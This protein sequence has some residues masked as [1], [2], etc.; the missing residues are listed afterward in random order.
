MNTKELLDILSEVKPGLSKH[1]FIEQSTCFIF[2]DKKVYTYNDEISVSMPIDTKINGAVQA[3]ELHQLLCRV[4]DK[5]VELSTNE[6]ELQIKGKK[7]KSGI[8][9]QSEILLPINKINTKK[10]WGT[11][12]SDFMAALRYCKSSTDKNKEYPLFNCVHFYEGLAEST[13][14]HRY[15]AYYLQ[16]KKAFKT[17]LLI[18]EKIINHLIKCNLNKYAINDG[19]VHF[20]ND[21][22]L[23]FSCRTLSSTHQ[24][25]DISFF[26]E[27]S[28]DSKDIK[29]PDN[30]KNMLDRAK[31]FSEKTPMVTI[32]IKNG[33]MSIEGMNEAGWYTEKIRIHYK[34]KKEIKFNINPELLINILQYVDNME[35]DIANDKIKF[36]SEDFIHVI[37]LMT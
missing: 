2:K 18:P 19:W 4:K 32:T 23:Q 27:M 3:A 12:P 36:V 6:T 34:D 14:R 30:L 15:A 26:V 33:M 21:K 24:F 10:K 5:E 9:L 31:I 22:Q 20:K 37:A 25:P 28:G 29:L 17:P 11:L 7:F 16:D 13:D 35:I 8:K 1:S